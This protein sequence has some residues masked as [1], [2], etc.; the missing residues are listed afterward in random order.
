[1]TS[2]CLFQRSPSTPPRPPSTST[3][4]TAST[5]QVMATPNYAP[6]M[7]AISMQ[8]ILYAHAPTQPYAQAALTP[9]TNSS[10]SSG[11]NTPRHGGHRKGGVSN[12]PPRNEMTPPMQMT[13]T[14]PPILAPASAI[15][16]GPPHAQYFV[17]QGHPYQVGN[18]NRV[19]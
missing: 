8:P 18:C 19:V 4:A 6:Y 10:T 7:P 16:G 1:M 17:S 3:P 9:S 14:G 11:V 13:A 5:P 12:M 15:Q 2:F